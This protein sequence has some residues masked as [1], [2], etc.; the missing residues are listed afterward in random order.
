[1]TIAVNK[2]VINGAIGRDANGLIAFTGCAVWNSSNRPVDAVVSGDRQPVTT[3]ATPI[4]QIYRAVEGRYLEV[5]MEA[6]AFS[7]PCRDGRAIG[8]A[9]IKTKS[10][11]RRPQSLGAVPN[12]VGIRCRQGGIAR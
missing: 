10:A 9:A 6:A 2:T 12:S 4:G 3:A 8:H 1:M 7:G 11:I 5:T